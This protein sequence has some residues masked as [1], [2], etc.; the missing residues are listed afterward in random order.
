LDISILSAHSRTLALLLAAGL[1]GIALA[2]PAPPYAELLR[3]SLGN[4]PALLEQAANVR[5]ARDEARQA[6]ARPNPT[7]GVEVENLGARKTED[8][9]SQRQTTFSLTQP[10]EIG[11]K[12]A[13]RVAAG[14]A[15][16]VAAEAR[17]RQVRVDYAAELAIAYAT[18]EAMQQRLQLAEDDLDRGRQDLRAARA[19]VEAGK[20]ADLRLAQAQASL[21]AATAAR[22]AA[23]ADLTEAL[24]NLA[25]L[26]G[27]PEPYSGVSGSLLTGSPPGTTVTVGPTLAESPA[28]AAVQAVRSER[29]KPIPDI[30]LSGGVRRFGG[31]NDTAFVVGVSASIPLFDR[32]RGGIAAAE[33]RRA[34]AD[35]RLAAARLQASATRRAALAQV[36]AAEGRLNAARDGE[37]AAAEAYRLG[38]IGYDAG[39]TSLTELLVIRR[40]LFDARALAIDARLARV[41]ARAALDRADGR[42]AFGDQ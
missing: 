30:G 10:F 7:A 37:L 32:N 8:G 33:E 29:T 23:S 20:E 16:V 31:A 21:S 11:G 1:P 39:K 38:R 27:I 13:A 24:G 35:Q 41:R 40:A 15:E 42:L 22:E 18:A 2:D 25:A 5:A 6:R 26:A 28:V 14:E 12:R 4:A 19:L 3:R 36:A 9:T 17:D 34:A